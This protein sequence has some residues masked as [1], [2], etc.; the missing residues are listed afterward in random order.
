MS[1]HEYLSKLRGI[2]M[3]RVSCQKDPTR[4]AYAWQIRPFWQETLDVRS[5]GTL[6]QNVSTNLFDDIYGHFS[7]G[8]TCQPRL[9]RPD[10]PAPIAL[11]RMAEVVGIECVVR[12]LF[13]LYKR[14]NDLQCGV[15]ITKS[16]FSEVITPHSSTER[17][18]YGVFLWVET[19]IY[20]LP[21]SL[22]W[23]YWCNANVSS[24]DPDQLLEL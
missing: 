8:I 17:A 1:N 7:E 22:Q 11:L 2:H 13:L 10:L 6:Q 20:L 15:V 21:L 23:V 19:L 14:A 3:S 5:Y 9:I 24:N 18:R 12:P 4:H 16:I